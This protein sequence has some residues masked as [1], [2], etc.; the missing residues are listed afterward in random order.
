MDGSLPAACRGHR[1]FN[2]IVIGS[3]QATITAD[4][5]GRPFRRARATTSCMAAT[6]RY[7]DG[8]ANDDTISS[9][10]GADTI[11]GSGTDT[12]DY[13]LDRRRDHIATMASVSAVGAGR[14]AGIE[15]IEGSQN[16]AVLRGGSSGSTVLWA[17]WQR[18]VVRPGR[19]HRR[20]QRYHDRHSARSGVTVVGWTASSG[21]NA[22]GD[23]VLTSSMDRPS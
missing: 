2:E 9:G 23:I 10:L 16:D 13:K 21:G 12:A 6:A 8:G 19:Q 22:A 18:L 1:L 20:W 5:T 15:R 7:S 14:R 4:A 17:G 3:A 11:G